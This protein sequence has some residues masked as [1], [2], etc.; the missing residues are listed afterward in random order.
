MLI[1][2]RRILTCGLFALIF[3]SI[4]SGSFAA[5]AFGHYIIARRAADTLAVSAQSP[6][7]LKDALNDPDCMAAFCSGAVAPDLGAVNE[8]AHYTDITG[9][10]NKLRDTAEQHLKDA[11]S[12]DD[13]DPNKAAKVKAAQ[14]ELAFSYGWLSHC[15]TDMAIHPIVN[16]MVGEAWPYSSTAEKGVHTFQ[17]GMMDVIVND[18]LKQPGDKIVFDVP[19]NFLSAC[20]GQSVD[21]LKKSALTLGA[22]LTLER[23]TSKAPLPDSVLEKWKKGL[24]KAQLGTLL[25]VTYPNELKDWNLD[26][27]GGMT[28]QEFERLRTAA[29]ELNGGTLP[30]NWGEQYINWFNKTRG[31]TGDKFRE[32]LIKLIKG[33][34]VPNVNMMDLIEYK[35]NVTVHLTGEYLLKVFVNGKEIPADKDVMV[36]PTGGSRKLTVRAMM[37]GLKRQYCLDKRNE[38]FD[39]PASERTPYVYHAKLEDY[40]GVKVTKYEVTSETYEWL[41]P[42]D[43]QIKI[44]SSGVYPKVV[45][46]IVEWTVPDE[47]KREMGVAPQGYSIRIEGRTEWSVSVT[48]SDPKTGNDVETGT[49]VLRVMVNP[50]FSQTSIIPPGP[51]ILN[52]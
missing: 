50:E 32:T 25:F 28:T 23:V 4:A 47:C 27:G 15:G 20:S 41:I 11:R 51:F 49:G 33:E 44:A 45:N 3:I 2:K 46:D 19:Y 22:K 52:P 10:P 24:T 43:K 14:K 38:E 1:A 8:P 18:T 31:M 36:V 48:G 16:A 5:G 35:T 39:G 17:E 30:E 21:A 34:D 29:I 42:P 12:L 13:S 26:I 6:A 40:N 7:E 9:L 37:N